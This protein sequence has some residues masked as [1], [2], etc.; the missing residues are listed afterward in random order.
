MVL[1]AQ[2]G[3][4][5][6][7]ETLLLRVQQ[8]LVRYISGLVGQVASDDVLQEV[9]VKIWQ[10]LQWLHQPELFRPWV[11]R[12]ASR[13]C[14][15]HLKRARQ[16]SERFDEAAV[17]EDLPTPTNCRME[18]LSG[19]DRLLERVSP[20]SRAVLLFHYV[21]DLSIDETAAILDISVGTA[22]SRLAYGLACLREFTK[23]KG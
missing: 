5:A 4:P 7:L 9:F 3:D 13:A 14:Y 10:N 19:M 2:C 21:E 22:K 23:W 18:V 8:S 12:I 11:Y 1:L 6:A 15:Q 17:V 20:A 16:W